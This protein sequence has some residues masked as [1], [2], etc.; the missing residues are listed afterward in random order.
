MI[1]LLLKQDIF[2]LELF[3]DWLCGSIGLSLDC[4]ALAKTRFA[5][6]KNRR[7]PRRKLEVPTTTHAVV[8]SQLYTL[9]SNDSYHTHF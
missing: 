5:L 3:T 4:V 7:V 9:R 6:N 8:S 2:S 1:N